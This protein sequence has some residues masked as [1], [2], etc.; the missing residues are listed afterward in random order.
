M[1]SEYIDFFDRSVCKDKLQDNATHSFQSARIYIHC[2][3]ELV[4]NSQ[5][6]GAQRAYMH[7][8]PPP[9]KVSLNALLRVFA[10]TNPL[11]H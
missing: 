6:K 2:R 5:Q 7:E 1:T 8:R 9:R 10:S 3:I 4:Q 11:D